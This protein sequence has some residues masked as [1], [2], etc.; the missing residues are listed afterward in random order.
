MNCAKVFLDNMMQREMMGYRKLNI[1]LPCTAMPFFFL[2]C[3]SFSHS[4]FSQQTLFHDNFQDNI[5]QQV[6]VQKSS[7]HKTIV[8]NTAFGSPVSNDLQVG[9]ADQVVAQA[10]KRIGYQLETVRMPAERALINANRG[11]D[12]GDLVRVAGLEKKYPNLIRVPED[13]LVIDMVLFTKKKFKKQSSFVLEGWE[14]VKT[15][16]LAI[17]SGWKIMEVNF[18]K[19]GDSVEISKTD[20]VMQSFAML[21]NDRVDFVAYSNW[22]GLEYLKTKNITDVILL[23]PPLAQPKF[24]VYLHKKHKAI[25]EPLAGAIREM[26]KDGSLQEIFDNVLKPYLQ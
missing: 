9:Y 13:V 26:K 21:A 3:V 10:L 14:S 2:L 5:V 17:I 1:T 11:I 20:N 25:V 22:S 15:H 7:L 8:L 18:G 24:Y 19:L 12:D 23:S 6:S 16:S 4:V